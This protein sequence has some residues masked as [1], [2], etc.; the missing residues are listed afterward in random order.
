MPRVEVARHLYR[1]FP[2]LEGRALN[3][4]ATTAAEV[5][6]AMDTLAPGFSDYIV[7]ERGGLRPHVNLFIGDEMVVD[8][9]SLSDRVPAGATV[10]ILQALSGG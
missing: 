8:R 3:V 1:F 6:R 5:V 2:A 9:K 7:N 10:Y 4:E